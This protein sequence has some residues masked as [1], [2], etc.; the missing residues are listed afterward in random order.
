MKLLMKSA[1]PRTGES[2]RLALAGTL[3]LGC[4]ILSSLLYAGTDVLA[5][6]LYDGYS[7][8]SQ[9]VSELSASGVSTRPLIVGLFTPYNALMM[10]FGV[11]VWMASS[12]RPA[13]R[14]TGALLIG[15]AVVGEVTLL[16]FP[17]D[18]R[19]AEETLRGSLHPPLTAVMSLFI[20]LA[21]ASGATL[22]GRRFRFYS[23]GTILTLLVFGALAGLDAPRLEAGEA[24]PW[25]GVIERIN[26]YAYLLWVAALAISLLRRQGQ[27]GQ[28]AS[29]RGP[30]ARDSRRRVTAFLRTHP[31][32]DDPRTASRTEVAS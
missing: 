18:Q 4:G 8:K 10:A 30:S 1:T 5:G 29:Y 11:G 9:A 21:M 20:V 23:I 14:V 19:G 31:G 13:G 12:R 6:L 7:F 15:S 28:T 2:G 16:S 22:A 27:R 26:I 3:L 25:L 32:E 17:M 24:T